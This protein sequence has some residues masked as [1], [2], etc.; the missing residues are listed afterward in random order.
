MVGNL[1]MGYQLRLMQSIE[2]IIYR[3]KKVFFF[4]LLNNYFEIC[5]FFEVW[6]RYN[7]F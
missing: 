5:E 7:Q 3:L 6:F 2:S 1:L 4:E